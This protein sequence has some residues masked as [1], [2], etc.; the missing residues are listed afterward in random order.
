MYRGQLP[1]IN[2]ATGNGEIEGDAVIGIPQ[3]LIVLAYSPNAN[4]HRKNMHRIR[5]IIIKRSRK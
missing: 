2:D 4:M 1:E 5:D 3:S